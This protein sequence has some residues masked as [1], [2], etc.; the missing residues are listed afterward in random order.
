[1]SALDANHIWKLVITKIRY[2]PCLVLPRIPNYSIGKIV[3]LHSHLSSGNHIRNDMFRLR[4][5]VDPVRPFADRD[6]VTTLLEDL[7]VS[8]LV[9]KRASMKTGDLASSD[10]RHLEVRVQQQIEAERVILARIVDAD[11]K[12]Q[13]LLA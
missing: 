1:M 12:V 11:V 7:V 9:D 5:L 4:I 10:I 3:L 6:D 8:G 2:I 13:F